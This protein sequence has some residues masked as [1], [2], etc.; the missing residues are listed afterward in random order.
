MRAH[1]CV[2]VHARVPVT[3]LRWDQDITLP[4]SDALTAAQA[5]T[6]LSTKYKTEAQAGVSSRVSHD[7]TQFSVCASFQVPFL[8]SGEHSLI[9]CAPKAL[10]STNYL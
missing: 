5:L 2:P 4:K 3:G 7:A 10:V 1:V 6:E 9:L 8:A